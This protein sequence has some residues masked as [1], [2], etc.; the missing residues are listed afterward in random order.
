ML[1]TESAEC[2]MRFETTM[3]LE[4]AM[5]KLTAALTRPTAGEML[6]PSRTRLAGQVS[7]SRTIISRKR[8]LSDYYGRFEGTISVQNGRTVLAGKFVRNPSYFMKLWVGFL[9]FCCFLAVT[10]AIIRWQGATTVASL[11]VVAVVAAVGLGVLRFREANIQAERELLDRE[12][13]DVLGESG[14]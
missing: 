11:V 14:G 6:V 5:D 8:G 13:R 2:L 7:P 12:I 1:E 10:A 9:F 3:S 4:E